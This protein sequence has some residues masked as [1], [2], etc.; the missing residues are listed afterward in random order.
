MDTKAL[1]KH[2]GDRDKAMAAL[3]IYRQIWEY[4]EDKGIPRG[5][6]FEIQVQTAGVL[7]ADPHKK[8]SA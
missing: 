3:G 2:F 5:R 6:Q 8:V 4:W 1:E 7:R